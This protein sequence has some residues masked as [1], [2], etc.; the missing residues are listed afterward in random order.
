[1]GDTD[2][3]LYS[4]DVASGSTERLTDDPSG[5][6]LFP[7][8]SPDGSTVA[9]ASSRLDD[10]W[11]IYTLELASGDI[12]RLIGSDSVDRQ[13]VFSPDGKYIAMAADHLAVYAGPGEELPD[14]KLRWR[15]TEKPALSPTWTS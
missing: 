10:V 8:F 2:Y 9:F 7:S 3:S 6:D 12:E 11:Q 14:G 4:V 15:L 13:P 1:M 5:T